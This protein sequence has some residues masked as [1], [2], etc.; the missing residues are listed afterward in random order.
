MNYTIE[1]INHIIYNNRTYEG[2]VENFIPKLSFSDIEL[3]LEIGSQLKFINKIVSKGSSV[4]IDKTK[5]DLETDKNDIIITPNDL[6]NIIIPKGDFNEKEIE[7][8]NKKKLPEDIIKQYNISPLSKITDINTLKI[9]GITTHPIL[10][11]LIGDGIS[12]GLF[13]PMYDSKGD[14]INS[15][16]RKL[17][18]LTKI[19]YGMTIPSL[20]LYGDDI[21]KDEEIWMCEGLFDMMAL[22]REKK[23][24]ICSSS[25]SLSDYQYF[26]VVKSKPSVVNIFS[27]NDT[28]GYRSALKSK[29]LFN[30]NGI[31][32]HIF[33]SKNAKDAAE[34]FFELELD[35]NSVNEINVTYDMIGEDNNILDFL[36]YLKERVF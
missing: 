36:K 4:I 32:C 20:H 17:G 34:H 30:M 35:W 33:S 14:F 1:Q 27:D 2:V 6:K 29:K 11:K 23:R 8:I 26:K 19:K 15:V 12:D 21:I 28:T 13:I 5:L 24:C 7:L 10:E 25:C 9:L 18:N 22:R 16:F 3:L 31:E